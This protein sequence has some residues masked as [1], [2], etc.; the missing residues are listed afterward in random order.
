M[1]LTYEAKSQDEFKKLHKI[2]K[3]IEQDFKKDHERMLKEYICA[4]HCDF[5]RD[6]WYN[7]LI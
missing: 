6:K 5:Y 4:R 2:L 7:I 1:K 3:E